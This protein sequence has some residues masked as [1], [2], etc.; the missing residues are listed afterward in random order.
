MRLREWRRG[1]VN[2]C[3]LYILEC[4]DGSYYVGTSRRD[5]L[6]TRVSQHNQGTTPDYTFKR[7]PVALVYSCY[8]DK[9]TDA[10]ACERQVKGWSRAKKEAL[11]RRDFDALPGL[12]K[13]GSKRDPIPSS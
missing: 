10:I 8:F 9:I 7:R 6:E 5:D 1:V 12:S 2:G 13:R 11:I 4:S 3:W